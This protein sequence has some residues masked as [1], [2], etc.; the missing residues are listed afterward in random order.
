[1]KR[2]KPDKGAGLTRYG[3][4]V[5]LQERLCWFE[6]VPEKSVFSRVFTFLYKMDITDPNKRKDKNRAPF[7][8]AK[9]E[10]KKSALR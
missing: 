1:M 5:A 6:K 2:K 9:Q 4:T 8:S 7:D 3:F 10:R